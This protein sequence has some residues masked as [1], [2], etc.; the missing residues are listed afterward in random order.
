M[1]RILAALVLA[2]AILS[3]CEQSTQASTPTP[4]PYVAVWK[5]VDS[6]ALSRVKYDKTDNTLTVEFKDSGSVYVYY[7]VPESVY[8]S[9]LAADSIGSYFYYNVRDTYT[10][11][12]L[13]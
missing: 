4:T 13:R 2:L 6:T 8:N 3:G 9:L 11:K 12:R 10:Y 1:K 7:D 5:S